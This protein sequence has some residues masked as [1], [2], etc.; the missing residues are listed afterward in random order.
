MSIDLPSIRAQRIEDF[1][2]FIEKTSAPDPITRAW[3]NLCPMSRSPI[4]LLVF[5][6]QEADESIKCSFHTLVVG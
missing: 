2:R 6:R 4:F 1:A 5:H 3:S